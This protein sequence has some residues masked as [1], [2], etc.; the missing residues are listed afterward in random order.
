MDAFLNVYQVEF[1]GWSSIFILIDF[2]LHFTYLNLSLLS[3]YYLVLVAK[4]L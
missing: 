3:L 1:G 2:Q 4:L